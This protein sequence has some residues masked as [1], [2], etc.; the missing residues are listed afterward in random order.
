MLTPNYLTTNQSKN[1]YEL[2]TPS[3]LNHHYK[4]HYLLL[5][6]QSFEGISLLW[7]PLPGEAIK[8]FFSISLPP[9]KESV[10]EIQ[11][12]GKM[13]EQKLECTRS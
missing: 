10:K 2:I 5:C 8:L 1:G 9:K 13:Q 7:L 11:G 3:P 12:N 6:Q 4:S